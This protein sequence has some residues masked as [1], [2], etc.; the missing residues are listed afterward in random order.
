[1][2]PIIIFLLVLT[3]LYIPVGVTIVHE[4]S[5]WRERLAARPARQARPVRQF[6]PALVPAA[7]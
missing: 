5:N 6:R 7:A 3:P 4:F 1:M 2:F